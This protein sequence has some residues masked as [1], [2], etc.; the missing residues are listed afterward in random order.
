MAWPRRCASR[1]SAKVE[2]PRMLIRSI[3]SI[4]TATFSVIG[5][6]GSFAVMIEQSKRE[7][8]VSLPS[9]FIIFDWSGRAFVRIGILHVR[10]SIA[11][12]L[13]AVCALLA[14]LTIALAAIVAW[15]G[16]RHVVLISE[17]ES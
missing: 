9:Y 15:N 6:P 16:H 4:C 2:S 1:S 8:N 10:L 12:K 11:T 13:Y 14:T 17:F 7:V 5:S 3:G